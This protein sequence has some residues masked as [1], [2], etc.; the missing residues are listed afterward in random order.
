MQV[1]QHTALSEL[2]FSF[3]TARSSIVIGNA[4]TASYADPKLPI[5][6]QAGSSKVFDRWQEYVRTCTNRQERR[7]GSVTTDPAALFASS[8][9]S[10]SISR[11]SRLLNK[12]S[13]L[14]PG[15][16]P[17]VAPFAGPYDCNCAHL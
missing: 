13:L 11:V 14:S 4:S 6:L 1:L 9:A 16:L 5:A 7:G 15:A 12:A 17:T 3:D 2:S 10:K 8:V